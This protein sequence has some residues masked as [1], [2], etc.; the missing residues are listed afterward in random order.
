MALNELTLKDKKLFQR[1]LN[2]SRHELCVFSFENIYIWKPLFDIRWKLIQGRLCVFFQD[3]IGC[4]MYLPPLGEAVSLELIGE[5][6]SVMDGFNQNPDVSRIENIET[7][8]E[9][10][11][12]KLGL[13]VKAK[14]SDYL[15]LRDE[16]A[17]LTGNKFKSQRASFNYFT[18]H[19]DFSCEELAAKH[20]PQCRKLFDLW[21]AQRASQQADPLYLGMLEDSRQVLKRLF[22]GYEKLSFR[23]IVVKTQNRISGFTF[24]FKLNTDTFCI[25]YE[26]TDLSVKG[27]AQFIFRTFCQKLQGFKYI[28][29]MDDSGLENL[30]KTKLAYHP[31][32]LIAGYIATR[33]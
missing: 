4:F 18:K 20:I 6:F 30:K 3:K 13:T 7:R 1:Y 19:Y 10:I 8:E 16:L 29:I 27:L 23:G 12:R 9:K 22:S 17:G 26:I 15:C 32:K 5:V 21:F 2:L 14:Y 11:Y 25:I 24:G 28:N 31:A 33:V